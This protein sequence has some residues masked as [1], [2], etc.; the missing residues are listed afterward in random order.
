MKIVRI[1]NEDRVITDYWNGM[2]VHRPLTAYERLCN[3]LK[4]QC[5]PM[6][7]EDDA[8]LLTGFLGMQNGTDGLLKFNKDN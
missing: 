3:G 5:Q 6:I 8:K 4:M 7:K 1:N 2:P